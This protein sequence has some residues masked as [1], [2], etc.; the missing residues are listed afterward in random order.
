MNNTSSPCDC[1]HS[2]IAETL[3]EG[4][5]MPIVGF[6]GLLGNIMVLYVYRYRNITLLLIIDYDD[7]CCRQCNLKTATFLQLLCVLAIVDILIIVMMIWDFCLVEAWDLS[8]LHQPYLHFYVLHP[9]RN[10]SI[11]LETYLL[12]SIAVERY[13]AVCR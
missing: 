10:I 12:V 5:L 4:V 8:V 1:Q 11:T 3:L 9:L 6:L 2:W 7:I 13:L